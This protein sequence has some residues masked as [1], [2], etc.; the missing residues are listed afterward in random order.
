MNESY[1]ISSDDRNVDWK[2]V[3]ELF[4]AVGWEDRSTDDIQ[5]AFGNSTHKRFVYDDGRLIGFGRTTDD[6]FNYAL[7]CDV[8][9]DPGFQRQGI[10]ARLLEELR[11]ACQDFRFLTLT[12]AEGKDGFY[13]HQGWLRQASSFIWPRDEK[14]A[15]IHATKEPNSHSVDDGIVAGAK[16]GEE[17]FDQK[18]TDNAEENS[19]GQLGTQTFNGRS[20]R[21]E[22]TLTEQQQSQLLEL[23]QREWPSDTR[24]LEDMKHV[25]NGSE[26]LVAAVECCSNDL[27]GFCRV[28]SDQGFRS[29]MFGMLVRED[30]R[31]MGIGRAIMDRIVHAREVAEIHSLSLTCA[32]DMIPFYEKWGFELRDSEVVMSRPVRRSF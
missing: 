25:V 21:L 17:S 16:A 2:R 20:I 6:G 23:Y 19:C 27:A 26:F 4:L 24:V 8:V 15:R 31:G 1:C 32:P 5:A 18:S 22:G 13:L 7:I 9:V 10:G 30:L 3:R 11:V 12:A 28:I 29:W 14:Q